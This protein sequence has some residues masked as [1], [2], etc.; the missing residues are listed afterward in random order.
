MAGEALIRRM[1]ANVGAPH[2]VGCRDRQ[3]AQKVGVFAVV[4]VRQTGAPLRSDGLDPHH[5]HQP[6]DLPAPDIK[7]RLAH[8]YQQLALEPRSVPLGLLRIVPLRG[9]LREH[10]DQSLL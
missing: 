5:A 1:P 6:P 9:A 4:V 3:P 8:H 10:S 7:A 2:L